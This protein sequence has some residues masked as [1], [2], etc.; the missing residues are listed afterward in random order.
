MPSKTIPWSAAPKAGLET[1][2]GSY[3]HE[4]GRTW[5]CVSTTECT[6]TKPAEGIE[7]IWKLK[8]TPV[9]GSNKTTEAS[10]KTSF[11]KCIEWGPQYGWV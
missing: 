3:A 6:T 9:R 5:K 4:D 1:A 11:T 10:T 7:N 8:P 2:K